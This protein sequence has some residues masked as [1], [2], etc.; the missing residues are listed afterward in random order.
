MLNSHT[1][2]PLQSEN[3]AEDPVSHGEGR[4]IAHHEGQTSARLRQSKNVRNGVS[5]STAGKDPEVKQSSGQLRSRQRVKEADHHE[6][7]DVLHVVK[8]ASEKDTTTQ[9]N[10]KLK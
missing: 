1:E 5:D 6:G 8:V 4:T 9:K 10:F 7:N 2:G 3:G